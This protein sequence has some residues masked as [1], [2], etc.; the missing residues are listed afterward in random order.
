MTMSC[1]KLSGISLLLICFVN[2]PSSF[3]PSFLTFLQAPDWQLS[4][5][6]T[7]YRRALVLEAPE[8][9]FDMDSALSKSEAVFQEDAACSVMWQAQASLAWQRP[10]FNGHLCAWQSSANSLSG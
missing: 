3:L 6:Q 5:Q 10:V 8:N 1:S 2:F 9:P 4:R 7:T